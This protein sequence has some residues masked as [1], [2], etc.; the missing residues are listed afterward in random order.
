MYEGGYPWIKFL[1]LT[2]PGIIL[3][4]YFVDTLKWK[5]LFAACVPI[6]VGLALAGKSINFHKQ[7]NG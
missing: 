6:G 3:M 5:L 2:I 4:L 1:I 7:R